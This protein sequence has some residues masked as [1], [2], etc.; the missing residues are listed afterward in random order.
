[1]FQKYLFIVFFCFYF[2]F[3]FL[4]FSLPVPC[5]QS[6]NFFTIAKWKGRI[7]MV[8]R[9]WRKRNKLRNRRAWNCLS[10]W[11]QSYFFRMWLLCLLQIFFFYISAW[12]SAE[13]NRFQFLHLPFSSGCIC[14]LFSEAC[15][16]STV[17]IYGFLP[18]HST[19]QY[20]FV[21]D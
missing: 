19:I 12:L 4:L 18:H 1:M 15:R 7:D 2:R 3:Y 13:L 6:F 16:S 9:I 14:D 11:A 8:E 17:M 5:I 21:L 20:L 10:N